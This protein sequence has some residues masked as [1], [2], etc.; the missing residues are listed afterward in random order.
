ME[1]MVYIRI[2]AYVLSTL[3]GLIPAAWAGWASY[4]A[5]A[6]TVVVSIE[7]LA[8]ALVAAFAGSLAIFRKWGVK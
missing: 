2:V 1:R 5:A 4:D 8:V 6:G 7:G 3:A